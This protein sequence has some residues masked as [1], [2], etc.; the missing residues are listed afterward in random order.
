MAD[1]TTSSLV[2]ALS[3]CDSSSKTV[4][5]DGAVDR[6]R[7]L[8]RPT[9]LATVG[10]EYENALWWDQHH[11][12][13]QQAYHEW[14]PLHPLLYNRKDDVE[15][16]MEKHNDDNDDGMSALATFLDPTLYKAL[17]SPDW[18]VAI[19]PL[20]RPTNVAGVYTFRLFQ[21]RFA[22]ALLEELR[23][24][25]SSGIPLRRPNGMN[26]YGAVLKDLGLD[27]S[28]VYP[29]LQRILRCVTTTTM[30][31]IDVAVRDVENVYP[32]V[33][34]YR[35]NQDVALATHRDASTITINICLHLSSSTGQNNTTP[36]DNLYFVNE[37]TFGVKE[38]EQTTV[39]LREPGAAVLHAGQHQHGV[40]PVSG[41]RSNLVFWLF[42]EDGYVRTAPYSDKERTENHREWQIM[43]G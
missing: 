30:A 43:Y 20:I 4:L 25:E 34:Q 23:H 6:A 17:Q 2:D 14:G 41:P 40:S 18:M 27:L 33:V 8:E 15:D 28:W 3:S 36:A 31:M 10:G 16:R 19:Q 29:T 26:R 13:L 38:D 39:S 1:G 7:R 35:Q 12:L 22:Q 9:P 42:G 24:Y 11:D 32:F 5:V 21:P 37:N